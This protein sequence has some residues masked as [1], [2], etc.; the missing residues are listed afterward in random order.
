MVDPNGTYS[1]NS[2]DY[3]DIS[4][5]STYLLIL[6]KDLQTVGSTLVSSTLPI[7]WESTGEHL[8]AGPGDDGLIDGILL[9]ITTANAG[10][11]EANF[12]I[13][14]VP[15]VT[16][17]ITVVPNVMHG[18]TAFYITVRVTELNNVQTEGQIQVLIPIDYRWVLNGPF[19]QTL[20]SLGATSLNNDSWVYSTDGTFHIFTTNA[21]IVAEGFSTF[22]F[23]ATWNAG[24][25]KGYFTATSQIVS[26][27]GGENRI[28]N[29][30]DA[31]TIDYFIY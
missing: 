9:V 13:I 27:S 4:G 11:A 16:P 8:G 31:E 28:D 19:N 5:D 29:N 21:S 24:Q 30:V 23:N 22:G 10:V 2:N 3:Q 17:I 15:D 7:E 1:F 26:G 18:P 25:T 6:T 12:G 14:K 20:T